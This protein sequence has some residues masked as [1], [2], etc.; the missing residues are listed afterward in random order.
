MDCFCKV[1][2]SK[3]ITF[4]D[5]F[6]IQC[7]KRCTFRYAIY[8]IHPSKPTTTVRIFYFVPSSLCLFLLKYISRMR[9]ESEHC[10]V[11]FR[12]TSSI[13][14]FKRRNT[15][16]KWILCDFSFEF[17][18]MFKTMTLVI[19]VPNLFCICGGPMEKSEKKTKIKKELHRFWVKARK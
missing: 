15:R 5:Y 6:H 2:L 4:I 16:K 12:Q 8:R 10:T 14:I 19:L 3:T 7:G 1:E 9:T 18:W 17:I 11:K 13:L